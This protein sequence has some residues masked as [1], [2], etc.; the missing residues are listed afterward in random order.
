[1]NCLKATILAIVQ[2]TCPFSE[3]CGQKTVLFTK[4]KRDKPSEATRRYEI[5]P[6][7]KG[8][9]P[10]HH[11]PGLHGKVD[12]YPGNCRRGNGYCLSHEYPCDRYK[13]TYMKSKTCP[14]CDR[15]TRYWSIVEPSFMQKLTQYRANDRSRNNDED[16]G[17]D[18]DQN[19]ESDAAAR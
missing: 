4:S 7:I 2:F 1:M 17:D 14:T 8:A 15:D 13:W 3:T 11:C 5:M 6:P 10:T 18:D 12:E 19:E 9:R 16:K